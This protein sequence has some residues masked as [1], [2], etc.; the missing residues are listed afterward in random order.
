MLIDRFV[1]FL[2]PRQE[3]FFSLLEEIAGRI[4]AAAVVFGE[5]A[6]ANS[7]EQLESVAAR[8]KPIETEADKIC[9]TIYEVLDRTFVTPI[10]REDIASLTKALDNVV[11][12]MEHAATF[13]ALYHLERLTDPMRQLVVITVK[14]AGELTTAVAKLRKFS[15]PDSIR[16]PTIAVHT[17]ENEADVI[18]RRAVTDLFSNGVAPVELIRQ[19]DM[20][21]SLEGGVDRCEDAMDV[22]RSV[23]VKNG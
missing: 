19:K 15:E 10:D 18:F 22:I 17:L 13:A 21:E 8:I 4:D 23:I 16:G 5:L 1:R 9:H 11:D 3:Q 20:L 7:R 2:F 14:A 6:V 12:D